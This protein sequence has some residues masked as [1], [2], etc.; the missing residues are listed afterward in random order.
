MLIKIVNGD[1]DL[2][3]RLNSEVVD[4][5]VEM[6]RVVH[7]VEQMQDQTLQTVERVDGIET[8]VEQLELRP[9]TCKC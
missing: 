6:D 1:P 7:S 2:T 4:L 8:R 5:R 9:L 3:A